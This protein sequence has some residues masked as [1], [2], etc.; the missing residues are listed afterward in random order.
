MSVLVDDS[1][2]FLLRVVVFLIVSLLIKGFNENFNI[3]KISE[4]NLFLMDYKEK[5]NWW[6]GC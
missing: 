1:D 4:V 6:N 3:W 5:G 2:N